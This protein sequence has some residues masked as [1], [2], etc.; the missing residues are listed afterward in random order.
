MAFLRLSRLALLAAALGTATLVSLPAQAD[1]SIRIESGNSSFRFG[2]HPRHQ[3]VPSVR[4]VY[5]DGRVV[6]RYGYQ[7]EVL[8]LPSP[9]II[10]QPVVQPPIIRQPVFL[11]QQTV[12]P[13]LLHGR[14]LNPLNA[15]VIGAGSLSGR[16]GP[17]AVYPSLTE[18]VAGQ[19]V[20]VTRIAGGGDGFDWFLAA[21]GEGQYAWIRGD[22]LGFYDYRSIQW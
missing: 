17:G 14:Q 16:Q 6:E 21:S 12:Q 8:V 2:H 13:R 19:T 10:Q 9:V 20:T 22:S 3:R 18:F 7:R 5:P 11:P 4:Y 15:L 1:V